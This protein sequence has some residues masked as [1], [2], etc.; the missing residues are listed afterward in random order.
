MK[1][2]VCENQ[3]QN[4]KENL[5]PRCGWRFRFYIAISEQEEALYNKELEIARKNWRE[6]QTFKLE[7]SKGVVVD[8][9]GK[10]DFTSI[11]AALNEISP[12]VKIFIKQGIYRESIS[13]NKSN[14]SLIGDSRVKVCVES[15]KEV[16][17]YSSA[18]GC[19]VRNMA[20]VSGKKN[21]P[22]IKI[23]GTDLLLEG[24]SVTSGS[25]SCVV[26]QNRANPVIR[27]NRI[28]DANGI[29][30][31][32]REHSRGI[33]E[34]ND[35]SGN[36][37]E[38]I[39]IRMADPIVRNNRIH[40]GNRSGIL[41]SEYSNGIIENNDISGNTSA[42]IIILNRAAPIVKGNKIN[43][44]N[45]VGIFCS[46]GGRG[47]I[48]DNDISDNLK[49]GI[50]IE[51]QA[52]PVVRNNRVNRNSAGIKVH[53]KGM[54]IIIKNDLRDNKNAP[55]HIEPGCVVTCLNNIEYQSVV[56]DHK[57]RLAA[58]QKHEPLKKDSK[59]GFHV[60]KIP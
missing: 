9:N 37:Q 2:P 34:N 44:R 17:L 18:E 20:F 30:I 16:A 24:C 33:I 15:A 29:A 59:A 12:G 26:I 21:Q 47:I 27:D 41:C 32:C 31:V 5:C 52:D 28:H 13:L 45:V 54:G 36:K 43:N 8:Q 23:D 38:G 60:T 7:A 11:S 10:G 46:D 4:E 49:T 55:L 42:G 35:I 56:P 51:N 48:E 14:I 57:Y 39:S 19:I 1:C 50:I 58:G 6:L 25:I 40:S 22:C 3:I 53:Q